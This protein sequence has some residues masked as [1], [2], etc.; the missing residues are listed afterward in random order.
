MATDGDEEITCENTVHEM[1]LKF[2]LPTLTLR[3][4]WALKV[5]LLREV[6][7]SRTGPVQLVDECRSDEPGIVFAAIFLAK[8]V[9][10]AGDGRVI[11]ANFAPC[12]CVC[13]R[14]IHARTGAVP[15]PLQ[16]L[17]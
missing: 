8:A 3:E 9:L 14:H 1:V 16:P 5:A 17:T 13:C 10:D 15:Q 6:D 2:D 7:E 4:F 11:A 12:C